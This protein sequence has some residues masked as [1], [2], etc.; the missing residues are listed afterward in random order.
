MPTI[1]EISAFTVQNFWKAVGLI[2]LGTIGLTMWSVVAAITM[3]LLM[4]Y[5]IYAFFRFFSRGEIPNIPPTVVRPVKGVY[6]SFKGVVAPAVQRVWGG[7]GWVIAMITWPIRKLGYLALKTVQHALGGGWVMAKEGIGG[8]ILGAALGVVLIST[9]PT[10]A[11]EV[12]ESIF[13]MIGGAGGMAL[14]VMNGLGVY[15][16]QRRAENFRRMK[17]QAV[18]G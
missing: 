7:L 16:A 1:R 11:K 14:G 9:M 8:G 2:I 3:P 4:G 18:T 12:P 13:V 15:L 10:I 5:L 6:H 17:L